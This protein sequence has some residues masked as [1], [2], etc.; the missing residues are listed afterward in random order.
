[1]RALRVSSIL[2]LIVLFLVAG[3]ERSAPPVAEVSVQPTE[4]QLGFPGTAPLEFEWRVGE[5]LEGLQ[6]KPRVFVHLLEEDGEVVRT[7]D[8]PLPF[9]W[10]PGATETYVWNIEQSAL[11]PA[12]EEGSY[13]LTIGLYDMA[14][15]RWPLDVDGEEVA[16]VEYHA[17]TLNATQDEAGFPRFYFSASWLPVEGGTDRQVLG[18]RW[19]AEDGV[20]RI[21]EITAPGTVRLLVGIPS[22]EA[23]AQELV[24]EGEASEPAVTIGSSC[25]DAQVTVTG[26]GSH[27]VEIPIEAGEDGAVPPECE[28]SIDANYYLLSLESLERRTAALESVS[29]SPAA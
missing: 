21:G 23:I 7:F 3:C 5:T 15:N 27:W 8:H 24:M 17:A 2:P 29:W 20:L 6:G 26:N 1:M 13:R 28:L 9:E 4:V 25:G 12:L 14:G 16:D 18:R 22:D 10:R 11:V 19:L